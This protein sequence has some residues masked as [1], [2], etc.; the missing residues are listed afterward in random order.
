MTNQSQYKSVIIV[1][2]ILISLLVTMISLDGLHIARAT[3]NN[4]ENDLG[5]QISGIVDDFIG[6][7]R[8]RITSSSSCVD[9]GIPSTGTET[10]NYNGNNSS[11]RIS[12][13]GSSS[14]TSSSALGSMVLGESDEDHSNNIVSILGGSDDQTDDSV[15]CG[16]PGND[17][18]VGSSGNNIIYGGTGYDKLFGGPRN[19]ILIG[20]PGADY[21]DCGTGNDTIRDYHPSEGDTKANDCENY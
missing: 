9:I 20:G 1:I 10:Q 18:L 14:T 15:I 2:F 16:G 4:N 12:G 5:N 13:I 21:F 7:V 17:I 3:T 11:Y 8:N 19:D 6:K